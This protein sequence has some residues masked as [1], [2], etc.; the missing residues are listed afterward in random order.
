AGEVLVELWNEDRK[1]SVTQAEASLSA[2][3]H[4][5]KQA[6]INANQ[7]ARDSQR[8]KSLYEKRLISS[9]QTEAAS[10]L[11][12]TAQQACDAA[13]DQVKMNQAN[14]DLAQSHYDLTF[15]RAPYDGVVV[16]VNSELGEYV[17]P[18]PSGVLTKP[19][20]EMLDNTCLYVTAPIDEVDAKPLR[21]GQRVRITLDAFR[22]QEFDGHL[23]RVAPYVVEVEKQARTVDVDVRFD[24]I[25]QDVALLIGYSADVE[26]V[27]DTRNQV[28]RIPT[29]AII[30]KKSAYVLQ[31][32]KLHKRDIVTG[33][34]NW[35]MT[36]VVSGLQAGDKVVLAP[37]RAGIKEGAAAREETADDRKAAAAAKK[38]P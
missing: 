34:S 23:T 17:T 27:L 37:D 35:T 1:A 20:I 16:E 3:M 8:A 2:A 11:S 10:T 30:D 13:E 36:E 24:N 15:L 7:N 5:Q 9:A 38:S 21:V 12:R 33:L 28:L 29:E 31:D 14:L 18:S 22:G 32:G 25:P 6:C 19:V 26:I 4:Q